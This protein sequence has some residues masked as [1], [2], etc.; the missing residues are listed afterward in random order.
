MVTQTG[1]PTAKAAERPLEARNEQVS[2]VSRAPPTIMSHRHVAGE[3]SAQR[4]AGVSPAGGFWPRE[5]VVV[6]GFLHDDDNN[7]ADVSPLGARPK[8]TG[9]R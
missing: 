6:G 7:N 1:S 8:N 3:G 4:E 2:F 5:G 9:A